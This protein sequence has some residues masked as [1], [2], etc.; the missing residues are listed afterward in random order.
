VPACVCRPDSARNAHRADRSIAGRIAAPTA[1]FSQRRRHAA[2]RPT[3]K[4]GTAPIPPNRTAA[5]AITPAEL[6]GPESHSRPKHN[7]I[8]HE[9]VERVPPG[10]EQR[11][12]VEEDDVTAAD[13]FVDHE[14]CVAQEPLGIV[15]EGE[16]CA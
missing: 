7:A 9:P 3:R 1:S 15:G 4:P 8:Q 11:L 14:R 13:R 2:T 6:A 16:P 12:V 10:A 5:V